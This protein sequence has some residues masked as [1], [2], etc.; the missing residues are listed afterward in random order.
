MFER[1]LNNR[2]KLV[3]QYTE[4]QAGGQENFGSCDQIFIL[5]I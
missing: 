4:M 3:L 5:N 2:I 1:I